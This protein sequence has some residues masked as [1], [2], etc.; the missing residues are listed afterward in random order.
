VRVLIDPSTPSEF[1]KARIE[2]NLTG[3]VLSFRQ[4]LPY[5]EPDKYDPSKGH[6]K[7]KAFRLLLSVNGP[8]RK[9]TRIDWNGNDAGMSP[10]EAG[11]LNK[12]MFYSCITLTE[13]LNGDINMDP[14]LTKLPQPED[15]T[16]SEESN[17]Q[18]WQDYW[19]KSG[20]RLSDQFLEKIW[21]HNLYFLNCATKDGAITPGLFA[22]WS[23]NNIGTA[24]H[25]DYHM[26]YNTQQPFWVTFSSNHLEKNIPYVNLIEF[27][28]DV[29][30][31]W[32]RNIKIAGVQFSAQCIPVDMT[33]N[34][35]LYLP[36]DGSLVKHHG[37][38]RDY[39]GINSI[40]V[41][42]KFTNR[43]YGPVKAAVEFLV[44]YM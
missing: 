23:Y 27:L 40:Q 20:V 11:L 32:A 37:L 14:P 17:K 24:W 42:H 36:G 38:F 8:L 10:L 9:T 39:C 35:Y 3:G 25:G 28:M 2:E 7:D 26:N 33:M 4:I 30:T 12:D 18:I 22:N 16:D 44:A 21:Y 13:G 41:I 29:S 43:A 31:K 15:M 34:P 1:P 6:P 19:R 5:E